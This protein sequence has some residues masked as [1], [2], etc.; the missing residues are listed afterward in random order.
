MDFQTIVDIKKSNINLNHS[1]GV[2]LL[3][4]CFADNIGIFL[5]EAKFHVLSNPF[6]TLYNPMSIAWQIERCLSGEIF[7]ND[8]EEI[9]Q[10]GEI[11]HSWMHHTT[12]SADSR[13]AIVKNMNAALKQTQNTLQT[14]GTLIITFGTSIIYQLKSDGR[15]VANCHK[16]KDSL[17]VR[18]MLATDEIS[19]K[20]TVLCQKLHTF[21]PN[22]QI[23]FTVS[24]IRHKRDGFH[25][26]QLSKATLLL[27]TENITESLKDTLNSDYFPSYE[28]MMDELRDYRFY[29]DDM[30]HPSAVAVKHI[31]ERFTDTYISKDD[32]SVIKQCMN[33]R[34]GL[35]HRT[36]NPDSAAY[37]QF[38]T[39]IQQDIIKLK[40][41][42]P[43][44]DMDEE[45][46]LCSTILKK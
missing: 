34:N 18:K 40:N 6:G 7:T 24:P 25:T 2:V 12:F 13:D 29:A 10:D 43:Y 22:L 26:N 16:Q 23:I 35:N 11:L 46:E 5:K 38:I 32:M 41:R 44:L 8:S 14:A 20:W 15:L 9:F 33:I 27:A 45:S 3:G 31:W 36:D 21:N 39:T 1:K 30:I 19:E 37:K 17:F 4:S 42:Y 28:I